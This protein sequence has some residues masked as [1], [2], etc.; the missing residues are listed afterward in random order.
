MQEVLAAVSLQLQLLCCV[1]KGSAAQSPSP[2]TSSC[3]LPTLP[4]CS[5]LSLG[6]S[7]ANDLLREE[8]STFTCPQH[9]IQ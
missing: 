6:G 7:D 8:Y 4:L 5:T 2:S 1:Q 3:I 9:L